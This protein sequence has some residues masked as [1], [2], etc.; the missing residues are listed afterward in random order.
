VIDAVAGGRATLALGLYIAA[1]VAAG[2][3]LVRRRDV[4]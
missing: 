3:L 2:A 1:F 4:T